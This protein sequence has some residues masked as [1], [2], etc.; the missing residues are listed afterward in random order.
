MP[1]FLMTTTITVD[2]NALPFDWQAQQESNPA[3][4][5]PHFALSDDLTTGSLPTEGGASEPDGDSGEGGGEVAPAKKPDVF[6]LNKGE[7][8]RLAK[9]SGI[10]G[11]VAPEVWQL[12]VAELRKAIAEALRLEASA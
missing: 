1:P 12:P 3:D 5:Q 10:D 8:R 2:G 11:A 4:P 6:S 7:L 9:E